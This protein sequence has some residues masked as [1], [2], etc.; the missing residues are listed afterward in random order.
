MTAVVKPL[1]LVFLGSDPIALPALDWLTGAGRSYAEVA[2]VFT[3]P[4]RPSGRGRQVKANAI[5]SWALARS[6]PVWQPERLGADAQ[7]TL[8]AMQP[9]ASL[10]LAYGHILKPVFLDTPR[11][12]TLN[13]HASL[14]PKFRGAS[15]IQAAIAAGESETGMSLIR[16]VPELDAGPVADTEKVA[17]AAGE[18]AESLEAKLAVACVPLLGRALPKL[19]EG[20]LGFTEQEHARASYCR[21]LTKAD[22]G[23]DFT[24]PA[25]ALARRINA[26]YPWPGCSI[27]L[28]G[29]SLRLGGADTVPLEKTLA[30]GTVAGADADG[31]VVATGRDGLRLRR[32]QRAGGRMM[33]AADFLRG[34]PVPAGTLLPSQPMPE[35]FGARPFHR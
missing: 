28:D 7:Q 18:T 9:D 31:L 6:L 21:R 5:K 32:M 17:V 11:L 24:R 23:L 2:G 19:A 10:V 22:G 3:Q 16:L 13:L 14:L 35:F 4:D 20:G 33:D 29:Q 15:P 12:G 27:A 34:C 26:L 25:A 1:R 30:P 8:A